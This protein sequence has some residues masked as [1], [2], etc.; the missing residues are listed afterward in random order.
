MDSKLLCN[1]KTDVPAY[2]HE[3]SA[4]GVS[5]VP[6]HGKPKM[7]SRTHSEISRD[8][9][10]QQVA[11]TVWLRCS[12]NTVILKMLPGECWPDKPFARSVLRFVGSIGK[13]ESGFELTSQSRRLSSSRAHQGMEV[14]VSNQAPEVE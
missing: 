12:G 7:H 3:F 10:Q 6:I 4:I 9:R 5:C 8:P 13:P 1:A 14:F 2:G 11:A